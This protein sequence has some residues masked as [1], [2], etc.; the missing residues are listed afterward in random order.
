MTLLLLAA[1]AQASEP[2][3]PIEARATEDAA[4]AEE[5]GVKPTLPKPGNGLKFLGLVQ[6]KPTA[7]NLTSTN[8]FLDGQVI[9]ALGGTSG[10]TAGESAGFYT[11]QR[12]G[13]FF[14]YA[15]PILDGH[16]ALSAGF[17]VDW[18]MGD[19]SY[20]TGGNVGGGF[21][22]DGVNL[23]T[24]RM[25]VSLK[26][27]LPGGHRLHV[28]VGMQWLGD[29]VNDPTASRPDDLFRSGG[30]VMFWGSEAAGVAAYGGYETGWGDRLRYRLGAFSLYERGLTEPD[31]VWIAVVD[32]QAH[33][34]YATTVGGHAWALRDRSGGQQGLLGVGPSS[35]LAEWQGAARLDL[36]PDGEGTAPAIS[37]D[38]YWLALDA[39]YNH[40]LAKG[41][42]GATALALLNTGTVYG[43]GVP[44]V[45][46]R[47]FVGDAEVRLRYAEGKGS[48]IRVEG[49]YV[50][51]DDPDTQRYEGVFTGNT[52]G[53]VGA[54]HLTHG[55][56]L[57]FPDPFSINRQLAVVYDTSAAGR[58][59]LA[60]SGSVGY[61]VIPSRLTVRGGAAH[62]HEPG[63]GHYGTEL[64]ASVIAEPWLFLRTGLH[65]ATVV[66]RDVPP[67]GA[68]EGLPR[69][70]WMVYGSLDW[71][72]F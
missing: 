16:A 2:G 6:F 33:P 36:R 50:S 20:S 67:A 32:V 1:L 56:L 46:V 62:A 45:P 41:P 26:P 7:T 71:V 53:I 55:C 48:V 4:R 10:M 28:I 17:E 59:L 64:N 12:V 27:D 5:Q 39:A 65:A 24:R 15:P 44:N 69:N 35:S 8:P 38:L 3:A 22:A 14:T 23:Q 13:A 70:P 68:S 52:Y 21:G 31:D 42:L 19:Q 29:S 40:N 54:V 63:V 30:R 49:L 34:L 25:N 58:G 61:D 47:G 72:V 51:A 43:Q 57:L 11:E 9:G 37:T 18:A 66:G 60:V